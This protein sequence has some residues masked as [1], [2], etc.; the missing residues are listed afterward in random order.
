MLGWKKEWCYDRVANQP[1]ASF[2]KEGCMQCW[3][4]VKTISKTEL[5]SLAAP[6]M[7]HAMLDF[8]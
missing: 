1:F 6:S 5:W 7:L 3:T 2:G 8:G 4:W